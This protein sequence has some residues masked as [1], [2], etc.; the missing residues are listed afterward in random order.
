[1]SKGFSFCSDGASSD[2]D[3]VEAVRDNLNSRKI[4]HVEGKKRIKFLY[5]VKIISIPLEFH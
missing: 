5:F 3:L 1:M 4:Y 2:V